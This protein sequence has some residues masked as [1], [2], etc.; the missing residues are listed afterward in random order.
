VRFLI[1]LLVTALVFSDITG[2]TMSLAPGLSVKNAILYLLALALVARLI[3]SEQYRLDMPAVLVAFAVLIGYAI[4]TWLAAGFVIRYPR[5]DLVEAGINLK[6]ALIDR[7][8]FFFAAFYALRT[9]ADVQVVLRAFAIAF[10]AANFFTLTDVMGLTDFGVRIGIRGAELGRVFGVF[11]H[12]NETAGLIACVLPGV[13]ALAVS[14]RG[15]ARL[16]WWIAVLI[17]LSVF[18]MTVSRGAWVAAALGTIAAMYLCRRVFPAAVLVRGAVVAGVG[19][20]LVG[21]VLT[22]LNPDMGTT[23]EERIMGQSTALDVDE[24]SSGRTAIWSAALGRMMDTPISLLTGFG[25]DA[26]WTMPF[27]FAPHNHYLGLWFELGIPGLAAFVFILAYVIV[28]ARRA[29]DAPAHPLRPYLVGFVFGMMPL[30]I[31]SFF[32]DLTNPWSYVWIYIGIAMRAVVLILGPQL[33]AVPARRPVPKPMAPVATRRP[34]IL[35]PH[36]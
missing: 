14:S 29:L 35:G 27:R 30:S 2:M 20:T 5:Y 34:R 10:T 18:I 9:V 23:I 22:L 15:A 16:G 33:R 1:I 19:I 24:V 36:Q 26:Y 12:A 17:S 28:L 6:S 11:G 8:L 4:L 3:M 7:A 25:W 32:G 21:I 31:T 13:V